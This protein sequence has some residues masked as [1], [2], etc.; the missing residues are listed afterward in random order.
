MFEMHLVYIRRFLVTF[1]TVLTNIRSLA[2]N[3]IKDFMS[4]P[5][6]PLGTRIDSSS[7]Q[8]R[9][10]SVLSFLVVPSFDID[11][12]GNSEIKLWC[13]KMIYFKIIINKSIVI[14]RSTVVKDD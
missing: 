11:A 4:Q 2:H 5:F 7:T 10:P 13:D 9:R 12:K 6:E 3:P 1:S 14:L 8:T